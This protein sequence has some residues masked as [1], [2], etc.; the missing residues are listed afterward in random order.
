M[1]GYDIFHEKIMKNLIDT[2]HNGES[3]HAY[4][5]IGPEG[6]GKSKAARLFSA[7]L[8]CV[9]PNS[10]PCGTCHACIGAKSGTNPDIIYI[11]PE[12]K[13]SISVEQTRKIVADAYLKPFESNKK[14]YIF[15]DASLLNEF[16]QNSL[17][18]ILEEPPEYITFIILSTGET[19][20]LQTVVSRCTLVNFP[21]V[22]DK[23]IEDYIKNTYPD[24]L[25]EIKLLTALSS[26]IP[27]EVD[28]IIADPDYSL[29]REESFKMLA[30]LLSSHKISAY[31]V[32]D[33]LENHKEKADV[34]ISMWQGFLR[35]I[36]FIKSGWEELVIN[37]DMQKELSSLASR[38]TERHPIIALEQ[39]IRSRMMLKRNVNLHVLA[40]NLSFSIKKRLY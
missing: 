37:K 28:K 7:A 12:E 2:I 8:T 38:V 15:E 17:L 36:S 6:V 34:I 40:L 32:A 10:A 14:V 13:K 35:D 5:F 39:T 33:F 25:S 26:G 30:P 20:L 18:K 31:T 1:Y 11:K 22:S 19:E 21:T 24:S 16:A 4:L 23:C 29:L 27:A 9:S 3:S